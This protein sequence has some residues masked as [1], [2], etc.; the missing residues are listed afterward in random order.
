MKHI[1]DIFMVMLVA[2]A[3]YNMDSL[4]YIVFACGFVCLCV[5]LIQSHKGGVSND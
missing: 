3:C 4:S 1:S 2:N 5:R